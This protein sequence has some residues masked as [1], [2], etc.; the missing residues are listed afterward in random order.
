MKRTTISLP[1]ELLQRVKIRA[2]ERGIS[3]AALIRETLE[4]GALARPKPRLGLFASG[5]DDN[6]EEYRRL[7]HEGPVP[8]GRSFDH[9]MGRGE[10][11]EDTYARRP[12][13]PKKSASRP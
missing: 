6:D 2:A 7:A 10:W 9:I 12:A 1:E 8:P 11:A 3:M 5:N 13:R 4:R